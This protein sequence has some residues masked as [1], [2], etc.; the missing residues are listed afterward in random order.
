MMSRQHSVDSG[1]GQ[2][3]MQP[4]QTTKVMAPTGAMLQ[5]YGAQHSQAMQKQPQRAPAMGGLQVRIRTVL[6]ML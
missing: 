3:D 4:S 1:T 2:V 6:P 5:M